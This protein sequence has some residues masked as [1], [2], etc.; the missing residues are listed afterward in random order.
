MAAW[1]ARRSRS[2][3]RSAARRRRPARRS[4]ARL[5]AIA[6]SASAD[7]STGAPCARDGDDVLEL[8]GPRPTSTGTGA[9]TSAVRH[10][11]I[12]PRRRPPPARR[13]RSDAVS[14]LRQSRLRCANAPGRRPRAELLSCSPATP[15]RCRPSAIARDLGLPR[16]TTYHLLARARRR[17]LRRAPARGAPLR[18]RRRRLRAR[19]RLR[20]PGAAALDRPAGAHAGSSTATTHNA[21]LAVLHGRDVLYVI[22]E[23]APG[24]PGLV[25]DV[26]VRLPAHLTASGPGDARRPAAAAGPRALPRRARR[27]CR[28]TTPARPR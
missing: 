20:A 24:R 16:S 27:S 9:W 8:S 3:R 25:T 10:A 1:P 19:H 2:R 28:A 14:D 23:R 4:R 11:T 22:E 7:S 17:G 6:A 26:G 5:R 12:R 21:H 18:A 15:R 13:E